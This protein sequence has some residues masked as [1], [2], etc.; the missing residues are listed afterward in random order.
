MQPTFARTPPAVVSPAS[1]DASG[2]PPGPIYYSEEDPDGEFRL[3]EADTWQEAY[4][5]WQAEI[6][7]SRQNAARFG[8]DD[9]TVGKHRRTG[10]RFNLR[11]LY[12]H[13]IE[14]YARHNGHADLIRERL[15]GTTGD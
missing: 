8:L 14:E 15:D 9:L 11:W 6:D 5:T 4:G 7:R 13:M 2:G 10:E 1:P 12:T 3:T